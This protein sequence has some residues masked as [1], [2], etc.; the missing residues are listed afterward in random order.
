MEDMTFVGTW[1]HE[2]GIKK[3][4]NKDTQGFKFK[5]VEL[6]YPKVKFVVK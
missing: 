6:P 5:Y 3:K 2:L 1:V 4:K